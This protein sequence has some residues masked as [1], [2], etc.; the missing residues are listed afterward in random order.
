MKQKMIKWDKRMG[1]M[2]VELKKVWKPGLMKKM[3]GK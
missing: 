3:H 1:N 2:C